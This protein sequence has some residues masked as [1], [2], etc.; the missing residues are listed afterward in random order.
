MVVSDR[1]AKDS[2]KL[3]RTKKWMGNLESELKKMKLSLAEV[4]Q[5]KNDLAPVEQA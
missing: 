5:L 1:M 3:K 2:T 4:G